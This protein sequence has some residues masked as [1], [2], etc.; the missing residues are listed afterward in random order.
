MQRNPV[1][2][3]GYAAIRGLALGAAVV[4]VLAGSAVA[5][6][7]SVG[8][9]GVRDAGLPIL[10]VQKMDT[11]DEA[12]VRSAQKE[13]R[14]HGYHSGPVDGIFGPQT[15]AA[16]RA[17]QRDAGLPV[18]GVADQA[19]VDHL[20]FAQ[21]KVTRFAP[22]G[23]GV[24]L[25]IQRELAKRGYYLGPV[26]GVEGPIT[27]RAVQAFLADA[28]VPVDQGI[29]PRLLGAIREAPPEIRAR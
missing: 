29:S 4:A 12:Y 16:V 22:A 21:P 28:K 7:L 14:G 1:K 18:T 19:L 15:R 3:E 9:A 27:R 2:R 6:P 20:M 26:D 23:T 24:V 11:M 25:D 5:A 8:A 10:R 13:L 17:Y